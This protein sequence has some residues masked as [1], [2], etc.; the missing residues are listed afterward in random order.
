MG[1]LK[2][3]L[4]ALC[5]AHKNGVDF[6]NTLTIGHHWC[7]LTKKEAADVL[8]IYDP[9]HGRDCVKKMEGEDGKLGFADGFFRYFGAENLDAIDYSGYENATIIH[10][11]NTPVDEMLK[12][13]YTLVFDGGTLEHVFNFPMAVKNCM[14]MVKIGGHLILHTPANNLFGHGFYQFSPELFFALLDKHNSFINTKIFMQDDQLNWYEVLPF[15]VIRKRQMMTP[16]AKEALMIVISQKIDHVPQTISALQSDY[17]EAWEQK[18]GNVN[19]TQSF[20]PP[21]INK[22]YKYNISKN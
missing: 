19:K 3:S 15:Q 2:S 4:Q 11:L 20:T 18:T 22:Y 10:D 8:N 9:V 1:I 13:M 16:S 5:Y 6:T 12:N 17:V 14:D 21:P 7:Y